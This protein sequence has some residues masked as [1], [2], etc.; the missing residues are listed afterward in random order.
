MAI[1]EARGITVGELADALRSADP[2]VVLV[3]PRILRRVLR[4]VLGIDRLLGHVPHR[5]GFTTRTASALEHAEGEELGLPAGGPV[6]DRLIL[7]AEPD[8]DRIEGLPR[9]DVL[10][11][12]W[13]SLFHARVHLAF[14]ERAD[15]ATVGD[16]IGERI[17]RL[18]RIEFAEARAVLVEDSY[19]TLPADDRSTFVEFAAAYLELAAF[20]PE[21]LPHTFPA[22]R[23]HEAVRALL[24]ADV[25]PD[26][27]LD[28]TRPPGAP[29]E[30]KSAVESPE[31]A[32]G[33][34][35]EE[36]AG[37]GSESSKPGADRLRA[38]A[39]AASGRGNNVRAAI[40]RMQASDLARGR[41][42]SRDRASARGEL[43]K[44][45][46]RLRAVVG[47]DSA[48]GGRWTRALP[49][50]L[51][52]TARGHWSREARLLYDLQTVCLDR[53]RPISAI[54]L[55]G[56]LT[57][58][59]RR[60]LRRPMPDQREV[61]IL[62][63]LRSAS[64]R[65]RNLRGPE[66]ARGEL[67]RLIA[68]AIGR[69]ERAVRARFREPIRE[70][71]DR[72]SLRPRNA[73]ERVA[74][75][76]LVEELLDLIV[77]RGFLRIG[78]LRDAIS[79]NGLKLHDLSGPGEFL[80][81]DPL[82]RA[83][84]ELARRLDGIYHRGEVYLRALQR[85]SSLAFGTVVGRW[86]SRYVALPFGAA[87]VVLEGLQHIVG[88]IVRAT[89]HVEVHIFNRLTFASLGLL[90][91]GVIN[92]RRFRAAF[93]AGCRRAGLGLKAV[94]YDAPAWLMRHPLIR[95]IVNTRT[96]LFGWNWVVKPFLLLLLVNL[97]V[98]ALVPEPWSQEP[99]LGLVPEV[100]R[101]FEGSAWLLLAII[102]N[103]R[104][105][106]VFEEIATDG[107]SRLG[108][109]IWRDLIPN[110]F[111]GIMDFFSQALEA[112]ERVLYAVDEWLRFRGGEGRL[113]LAGK[114][115][116]GLVWAVIAY[117][118]RIYVN[119][120][121]EPQ[122]NPIKHFPVVTV[123][124]KI[125]LPMSPQLLPILATPLR[126]L[127]K[128]LANGIAGTTIFLL[129]GVFGF[130]V[131]ELKANWR[132]YAANRPK[133]L[134]PVAFGHHGETMSRLLRRGFHSGTVPKLFARLRKA[135]RRAERGRGTGPAHKRLE[136][137]HHLEEAVR[138]FVERGVV[139]ALEESRS[140][141]PIRASVGA[142]DCAT[143]R[144]VVELRDRDDAGSAAR[145]AFEESNRQLL[146]RLAEPGWLGSLEGEAR[147]A[148]A[149]ALA[150]LYAMSDAD[151]AI[152]PGTGSQLDARA[153]GPAWSSWVASW[154]ADAE[155]RGHRPVVPDAG[156]LLPAPAVIEVSSHHPS[157]RR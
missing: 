97:G 51:G 131:W 40:L 78:D 122:V 3:P 15:P 2:R 94:F 154:E 100:W 43:E 106:R 84:A 13:R 124:H 85:A 32:E 105:G 38:A 152:E 116:L 5:G 10:L 151:L 59:G 109:R 146:I 9:E 1:V 147:C 36:A 61:M 17:D 112:I 121:I 47:P 70:I 30:P 28:A 63:H 139:F 77:K 140:I 50:F 114:A 110:V 52:G 55:V 143:N 132:L 45:G 12:Y 4:G 25:D 89:A 62:K 16:R 155:G 66:P 123:S 33:D 102:A 73:P 82:L 21:V 65:A 31:V 130:L 42:R 27:L 46:R 153:L 79:R 11:R 142:V 54:D 76:K 126:P 86:L 6:P 107:A 37:S 49:A 156:R 34:A 7:L 81:G 111:R 113:K 67:E 64:R 149:S 14:D 145:I 134:Q 144:V 150:G 44:L 117:L 133:S 138:E 101:A 88:P 74:G 148:V 48:E 41:E 104:S 128:V 75:R 24:S 19:L 136:Q 157:T 125:I 137:V 35:E 95:W 56:W 120:L 118:A 80:R 23:D 96:F 69:Q 141:G 98:A 127:G 39:D 71:L 26:D 90:L 115:A 99:Y 93:F 135:D 53:E 18:G 129:P 119:L 103:S 58:F 72:V 20:H 87:F 60:P 83:D 91:L 22:I 8:A 68:A 92:F 29:A 57:S 108:Q